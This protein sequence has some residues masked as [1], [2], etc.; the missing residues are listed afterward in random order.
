MTSR[1]ALLSLPSGIFETAAVKSVATSNCGCC[2]G[3]ATFGR[4]RDFTGIGGGGAS[5]GFGISGIGLCGGGNAPGSEGRNRSLVASDGRFG[6]VGAC[7]GCSPNPDG[8]VFRL[9]VFFAMTF[10][11]SIR[12]FG[13]FGSKLDGPTDGGAAADIFLISHLPKRLSFRGEVGLRESRRCKEEAVL[14]LLARVSLLSALFLLASIRAWTSAR[15]NCTGGGA[16][17]SGDF[18]AVLWSEITPRSPSLPNR[19]LSSSDSRNALRLGE[20]SP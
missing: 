12:T 19:F 4:W 6:G 7:L 9:P 11:A 14:A 3:F 10:G 5:T 2:N 15:D 20:V 1:V 17:I 13:E 8:R 18:R 16:N